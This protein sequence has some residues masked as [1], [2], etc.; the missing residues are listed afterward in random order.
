MFSVQTKRQKRKNEDCCNCTTMIAKIKSKQEKMRA[1]YQLKLMKWLHMYIEFRAYTYSTNAQID[2]CD[3]KDNKSICG[4]VSNKN[5]QNDCASKIQGSAIL[6]LQGNKK[7]QKVK[8]KYF[9]RW[10]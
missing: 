8:A 5:N 2:A 4:E 6:H 3:V 10:I 1:K 7:E 9:K